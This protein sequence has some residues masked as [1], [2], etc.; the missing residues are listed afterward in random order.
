[1]AKADR[2][3]PALEV[4]QARKAEQAPPP[5][6]PAHYSFGAMPRRW[7][8]ETGSVELREWLDQFAESRAKGIRDE[9]LG[10]LGNS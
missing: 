8:E 6:L 7:A 3:A 9:R 5:A 2:L 1:L 10:I 4:A